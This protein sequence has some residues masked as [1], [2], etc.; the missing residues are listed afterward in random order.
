MECR[1]SLPALLTRECRLY[2]CIEPLENLCNRRLQ[3]ID[4]SQI[5]MQWSNGEGLNDRF[6]KAGCTSGHNHDAI[7]QAGVSRKTRAAFH[8]STLLTTNE[9]SLTSAKAIRPD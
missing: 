9:K 4:V 8:N 3:R 6:A 7:A 5:A 1:V 2:H